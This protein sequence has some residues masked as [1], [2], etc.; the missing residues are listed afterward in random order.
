MTVFLVIHGALLMVFALLIFY[1]YLIGGNDYDCHI[2]GVIHG[3]YLFLTLIT[4]IWIVA[5]I[6]MIIINR[7][8][9]VS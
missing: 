3:Y 7:Y 5:G 1:M 9:N 8:K 2:I 6:C 4:V